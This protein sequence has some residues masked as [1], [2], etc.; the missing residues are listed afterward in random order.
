MFG[1]A[2][3]SDDAEAVVVKVVPVHLWCPVL[4][5]FALGTEAVGTALYELHFPVEAF[6]DGVGFTEAPHGG[7]GLGP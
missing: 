1:S 4:S 6:S 3:V 5:R 2:A 7:D